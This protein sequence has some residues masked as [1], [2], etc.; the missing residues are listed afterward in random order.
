MTM[1]ETDL[2]DF[3]PFIVGAAAWMGTREGRRKIADLVAGTAW[4]GW[5]RQLAAWAGAACWAMAAYVG[6]VAV[7]YLVTAR[8]GAWGGPLW[9]PAVVGAPGNGVPGPAPGSPVYEA[10]VRFA[11]LPGAVRHAWLAAHLTALRAGH[12]TLEQIP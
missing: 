9:W 12:I 3:T 11:A 2:T 7:V 6:C 8:Q 4:S 1:Q 5:A 10:A